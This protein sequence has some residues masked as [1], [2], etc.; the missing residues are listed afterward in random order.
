V[1]RFP[2]LVLVSVVRALRLQ[3][4]ELRLGQGAVE[5]LALEPP[6]LLA[7]PSLAHS[8]PALSERF[9]DERLVRKPSGPWPFPARPEESRLGL[10]RLVLRPAPPGR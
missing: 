7:L 5:A 4:A 10:V 3:L 9:V 1:Q 8:R 6:G 2:E